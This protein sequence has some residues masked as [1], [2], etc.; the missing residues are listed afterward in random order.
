M[1]GAGH[2]REHSPLSAKLPG[3]RKYV[4]NHATVAPDGATP[5]YDGFA[6]MW[7]DDVA[8]YEQAFASPEMQSAAADLETFI[9]VERMHNFSVDEE[10]I[11]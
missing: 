2:W 8:T 3:V 1:Q 9:D 5:P 4:Q 6:E 11:L 10:T 7:W